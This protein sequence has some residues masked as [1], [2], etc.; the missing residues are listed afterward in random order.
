MLSTWKILI[1]EDCKFKD[2]QLIIIAGS[3]PIIYG[4]LYKLDFP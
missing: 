4:H 2:E 1:P 3:A